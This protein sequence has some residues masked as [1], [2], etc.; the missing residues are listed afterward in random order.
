[1]SRNIWIMKKI[2]I[3][4]DIIHKEKIENEVVPMWNQW[5]LETDGTNLIDIFQKIILIDTKTTSN[6]IIET[7]ELFGIEATRNLLIE[8]LEWS[9]WRIY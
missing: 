7:F 5:I 4:K 9:I 3:N 1:M 8:Q 2:E 6:N